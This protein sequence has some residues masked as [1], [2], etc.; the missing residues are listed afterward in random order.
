MT[1]SKPTTKMDKETMKK[2]CIL[3]I[4]DRLAGALES[5]LEEALEDGLEEA[6]EGDPPVNE[7]TNA[8]GLLLAHHAARVF[9]KEMRKEVVDK[10][11][12]AA[13][14]NVD[15]MPVLETRS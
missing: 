10:V 9:P 14:A 4:Y 2:C 5:G 12:E 8:I 13:W 11:V 7:V 3:L 1:I 15:R 6:L